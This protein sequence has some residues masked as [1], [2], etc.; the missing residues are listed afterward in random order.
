[1]DDIPDIV[2]Y[3][4]VWGGLPSSLF[5]KLLSSQLK[6]FNV[7]SDRVVAGS[8]F[9]DL[10]KLKFPHNF[11]P[12]DLI[13]AVVFVH[14]SSNENVVDKYSRYV[15]KGDLQSLLSDRKRDD[16]MAANSITRNS[17]CLVHRQAEGG[18][19]VVRAQSCWVS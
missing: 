1:M 7:P 14:A 4:K 19:H 17:R 2:D 8:F 9:R 16:V 12:A 13:N 15:S 18:I 10:A 11:M 5:I 6:Q 3:V